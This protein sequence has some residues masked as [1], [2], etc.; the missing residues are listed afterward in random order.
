MVP[1]IIVP[2]MLMSVDSFDGDNFEDGE[3]LHWTLM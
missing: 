3:S 1:Y 2:V